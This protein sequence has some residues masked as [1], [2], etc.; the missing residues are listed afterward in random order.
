[1][2]D[3]IEELG[4]YRQRKVT[5]LSDTHV[6]RLQQSLQELEDQVITEAK[7]IDPKRG[8]LKLRTTV[9]RNDTGTI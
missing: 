5:D 3:L 7:K 6:A 9:L 2:A 8:T 4:N 1:M